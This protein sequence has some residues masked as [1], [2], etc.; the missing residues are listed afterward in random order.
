MTNFSENSFLTWLSAELSERMSDK[1]QLIKIAPEQ[2]LVIDD[3]SPEGLKWVHRLYPKSKIFGTS[4]VFGGI[5]NLIKNFFGKG[6][7]K[8]FHVGLLESEKL[9]LAN[10]QIDLLW[11]N[12]WRFHH[13]QTWKQSLAEWHRVMRADGLLMF[14]YLGPDTAKELRG[15]EQPG[16]LLGLDMHDM[17]DGLVQ[18]GFADPVMD[19]EYLTLTYEDA[20]L[21][22]KDATSL[23]FLPKKGI[24]LETEAQIQQLKSPEG[25][26]HLTLEVVYGH[27]W[28]VPTKVQGIATIRPEDI[29]IISKS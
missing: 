5:V 4:K 15:L 1:L 21:F 22:I 13:D 19:M 11:A 17:G 2:T 10:Q 25:M 7:P 23:G 27:A 18:A 26:W 28:W 16:A 24:S 6:I 20:S 14:S 12:A 3:A 9:D 8:F 29:K